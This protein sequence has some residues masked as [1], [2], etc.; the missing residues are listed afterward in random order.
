VVNFHAITKAKQPETEIKY[1]KFCPPHPDLNPLFVG[2][3]NC[4]QSHTVFIPLK[5]MGYQSVL[6][7]QKLR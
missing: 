7:N 6:V 3:F 4:P 2:D 1:F 5:K